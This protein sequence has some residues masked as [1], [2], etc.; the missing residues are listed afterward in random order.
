MPA[1]ENKFI[2]KALPQTND[3]LFEIY[4]EFHNAEEIK[5]VMVLDH[6]MKRCTDLITNLKGYN[7]DLVTALEE[8]IDVLGFQKWSIESDM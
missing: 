2:K 7:D 3:E 1:N 8:R 5:S 6:E 4:D